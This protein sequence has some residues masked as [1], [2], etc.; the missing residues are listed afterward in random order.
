MGIFS[1]LGKKKQPEFKFT[2][3]ETKACFTCDHVV[4]GERSIVY[5]AH[6]ADG[7]WHFMC[8]GDDHTEENAKIISLKQAVE[9]DPSVNDLYEMPI[10]VGAVRKSPGERWEP[11]RLTE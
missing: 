10:G 8:D 7:D 9:L 6:D 4:S 5:V 11:F 2:D 1:A 3:S